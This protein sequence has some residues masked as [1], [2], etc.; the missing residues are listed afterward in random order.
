M[1][2]QGDKLT[3]ALCGARGVGIGFPHECAA[4]LLPAHRERLESVLSDCYAQL[5]ALFDEALMR[6][7]DEE[8]RA[9]RLAV[10]VRPIRDETTETKGRP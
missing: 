7:V 5:D 4:V 8:L 10:R 3:C 2:E 9:L 6:R 1:A